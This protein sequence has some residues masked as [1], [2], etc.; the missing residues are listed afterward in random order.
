MI[1][2]VDVAALE[3]RFGGLLSI[4][5]EGLGISDESVDSLVFSHPFF[6]FLE[7]GKA[8]DFLL[9]PFS[10]LVRDF[11]PSY[12]GYPGDG[13]GDV[14]SLWAGM[15]YIR[16]CLHFS[17]PLK[18]VFLRL[19]YGEM[20]ALFSPYH[21]MGEK[22]LWDVWKKRF[23]SRSILS[24][25]FEK[26]SLKMEP[27]ALSSGISLPSLRQASCS[28]ERL[29]AM[30][31]QNIFRLV[32][33]L[34]VSPSFFKETSS[35]CYFEAFYFDD[36]KFLVFLSSACLSLL[37]PRQR[38]SIQGFS[39]SGKEKS[40][41]CGFV[42]TSPYVVD[43]EPFD[44]TRWPFAFSFGIPFVFYSGYGAKKT[45]YSERERDLVLSWASRHYRTSILTES[46]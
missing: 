31:A 9:R 8:N 7:E 15:S 3:K 10:S 13:E 38:E 32:S 21:E 27:V 33:L 44:K 2:S 28:N 17:L 43:E 41:N 11:Y 23:E 12:E 24:S 22:A 4:L 36:P 20:R 18:S 46:D 40:A 29:F 14:V 19:P 45:L 39:F 34:E 5:S 26:Q 35:F 42:L 30:S 16:I 37:R 6:D 1:E 25:L